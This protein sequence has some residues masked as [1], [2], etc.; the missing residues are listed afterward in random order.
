MSAVLHPRF[1][2]V[3]LVAT[4]AG[5][6]ACGGGG[7]AAPPASLPAT[8]QVKTYYDS[9]KIYPHESGQVLLGTNNQPTDIRDGLWTTWHSPEQGNTKQFEK[10][11]M[12]GTWNTNAYWR[13]WNSD[14]SLRFDWSDR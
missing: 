3:G 11:Y 5:L 7:A 4:L 1:G 13:E 8:A 6:S 2:R 9:E 12:N 14:T 10:T